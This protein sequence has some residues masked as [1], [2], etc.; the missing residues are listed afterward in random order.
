MFFY[1]YIGTDW[2]SNVGDRTSKSG[3]VFMMAG[4]PVSWCIEKETKTASSSCEAKY[5]ALSAAGE[6]TIW[7]QNLFF[8][9]PID[10]YGTNGLKKFSDSQS[11]IKLSASESNN[12]CNKHFNITYHYVINV[13]KSG[14]IHFQYIPSAEMLADVFTRS[15]GQIRLEV[16]QD[17]CGL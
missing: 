2:A 16:L 8:V 9:F 12:C 1:G 7:L 5:I 13:S 17:F 4:A 10:V 14:E 6:E 3:Y 11:A 15:L